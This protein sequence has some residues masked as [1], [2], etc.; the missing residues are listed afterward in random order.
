[1][2]DCV[3]IGAGAAGLAAGR[4]LH[5]A[6]KKLLILEAQD[7]IGGR[8]FT[9]SSFADIPVEL[10]AEFIHGENAATHRLLHEYGFS[11][12][13]APRYKNMWWAWA[14]VAKPRASTPE[15]VQI[16]LNELDEAYAAIVETDGDISLA[17]YLRQKGF[18]AQAIGFAD[19]YFAQT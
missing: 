8:M 9:D 13:D 6:G 7:R 18:D 4:M 15:A 16:L 10:G 17:D 14:D 2:Y 11:T 19:V 12:T 3:I 1:M 5:D